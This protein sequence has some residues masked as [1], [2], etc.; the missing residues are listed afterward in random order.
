MVPRRTRTRTPDF[1]TDPE[2]VFEFRLAERLS[3]TVAELR[4]TISNSEYVM[5]RSLDRLERA[6]LQAAEGHQKGG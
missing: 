3:R 5:W 4:R 1:L 2:L 6:A